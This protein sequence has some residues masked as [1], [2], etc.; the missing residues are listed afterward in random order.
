MLNHLAKLAKLL[1]YNGTNYIYCALT[2]CFYHDTYEFSVS[3][4]SVIGHLG[5]K[6]LWI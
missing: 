6:C 5:A 3:L 4:H 2:V 1:R